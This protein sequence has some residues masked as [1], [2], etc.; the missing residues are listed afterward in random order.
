MRTH[1]LLSIL[2]L[3]LLSARLSAALPVELQSSVVISSVGLK[4]PLPASAV[5]QPIP[6]PEAKTYMLQQGTKTWT[7]D[8][9]QALELWYAS[10]HVA[11]WTL[12]QRGTQLILGAMTLAP[13]I[14][15]TATDI[16]REQYSLYTNSPQASVQ[17]ADAALL[18]TWME[19][20]TGCEKLGEPHSLPVGRTRLSHLWR[21]PT[22]VRGIQSWLFHFNRS[23]GGL[24]HLPDV[25]IA[26][27]AVL[28]PSADPV[29][30]RD[31][32]EKGI[33]ANLS[34]MGRFEG[35]E[36]V[37][38]RLQRERSMRGVRQHAT[39]TAAHGSIANHPDWWAL[40]SEDYVLLSNASISRDFANDLL[41]DLQKARTLYAS[42]FP[43]IA[44][45]KE[46]VAIIRLFKT[47]E[48]YAAYVG[49]DYAWSAGLYDGNRRELILC[50]I[51]AKS[52]QAAYTRILKTARHEGFHQYIH[53]AMGIAQPSVWF[54]EG[55]AAFFEEMTFRNGKP[56][57]EESNERAR[58]LES[59]LK[60]KPEP[61]IPLRELCT[62]SYESF[63]AGTD[64]DRSFKYA[65]VWSFLYFLER[66]APLVRNQPY[67]DIL[68]VYFET[69]GKT[70]N[71][72]IATATAFQG[73]S[74]E[75]LERD[76]RSFW[77]D[78]KSVV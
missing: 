52:N 44:E 31:F 34:P 37:S 23:A 60:T 47:D 49:P 59:F 74:F 28:D 63:Y 39:R 25:W 56:L 50:P 24:S 14:G 26:L 35:R 42:F 20:F 73:I 72:D 32:I 21:Y 1:F 2:L 5:S 36:S 71:A 46:D 7:E 78:R 19:S 3:G 10:Q 40:D 48:E 61:S 9:Y 11:E 51:P 53:Q 30:E 13:P 18:R 6:P 15:F 43:G 27:V 22:G 66:G 29:A 64:A 68:P 45:T 67:A 38:D 33:L 8:R 54:N 70:G 55:Y 69:L 58:L 75:T 65:L 77:T 17:N 12:P 4:L 41:A 57:Y 16:T 62:M 76:F